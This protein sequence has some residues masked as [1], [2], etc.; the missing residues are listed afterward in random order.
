MTQPV[1][2]P[3]AVVGTQPKNADEVNGLVG[4]HMRQFVAAKLAIG[5][6]QDFF[7]ATD[8]KAAPYFFD[9]DQETLLKSGVSGLDTQ[10]D[11]TDMTFI[12]R[13]IGMA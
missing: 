11:G 10:L 6:D 9:A 12:N 4:L 13:I 5:Q 3:P 7:V 1:P 2:G 8:L